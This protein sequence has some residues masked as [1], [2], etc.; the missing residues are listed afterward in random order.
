MSFYLYFKKISSTIKEIKDGKVIYNYP[1]RAKYVGEL[2][3]WVLISF[4]VFTFP[5]G[6]L[7]EGEFKD[8]EFHGNRT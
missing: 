4:R 8:D 6:S 2:K 1:S 5:T 7:Y 3:N